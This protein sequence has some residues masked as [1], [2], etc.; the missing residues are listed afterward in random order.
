MRR[1]TGAEGV[2]VTIDYCKTFK[3]AQIDGTE[4]KDITIKPASRW[5]L[6]RYESRKIL[7]PLLRL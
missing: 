3:P 5:S 2:G 6:L 7:V 4:D 1:A